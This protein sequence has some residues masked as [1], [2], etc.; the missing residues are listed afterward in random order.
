MS[1]LTPCPWL[2]MGWCQFALLISLQTRYEE[3]ALIKADGDN[4][5]NYA[6]K[7]GRFFP[8]IGTF[9]VASTLT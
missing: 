1:I 9:D 6:A 2:V 8:N 4:Y 7:V 5:M 3:A